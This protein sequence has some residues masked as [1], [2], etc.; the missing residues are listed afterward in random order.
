MLTLRRLLALFALISICP[1]Q[2]GE[3]T[4]AQLYLLMGQSNMV[5]RDNTGLTT[6]TPN[7]RI[8]VFVAPDQWK[9]AREPLNSD[10]SGMGPGI[11]FAA[12]LLAQ[13]PA[14]TIGLIPTAVGGTALNRW[15]KGGDLY[16]KAIRQA[17]AA[18]ASGGQ[19][20]GVLWHQG[21]SD[22]IKKADADTYETRLLR[23]FADLR[24]DLGQP[25]LPIV[26][27]QLG[28]FVNLPFTPTVRAAL[29][30]IPTKIEHVTLV[31]AAGLPHKGDHLHFT[32]AAQEELGRRYA[33]AMQ[34]LQPQ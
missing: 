30:D 1:L 23:M 4:P 5:G 22:S 14:A 17:K 8:L 12:A 32:T 3:P 24:A 29:N 16:E 10:G 26:M 2:A 21:E 7:P 28:D 18:L 20:R 27:G 6:Q 33:K 31:D 15:V 9:V 13:D 25:Q 19:L 11:P 34:A